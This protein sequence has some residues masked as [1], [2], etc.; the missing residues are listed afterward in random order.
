[1][2][3]LYIYFSHVSRESINAIYKEFDDPA[4]E[5]WRLGEFS[6]YPWNYP[7]ETYYN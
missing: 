5:Y 4:V 6:F 3:G 2:L 1:M 7:L